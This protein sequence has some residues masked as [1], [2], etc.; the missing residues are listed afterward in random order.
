MGY[1]CLKGVTRRK[2]LQFD[3]KDQ[4]VWFLQR[5]PQPILS[6]RGKLTPSQH[7]DVDEESIVF[8]EITDSI[9]QTWQQADVVHIRQIHGAKSSTLD[10]SPELFKSNVYIHL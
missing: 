5:H 3:L 1:S 4:A 10:S 9:V 2:L 6:F 8:F 7:P